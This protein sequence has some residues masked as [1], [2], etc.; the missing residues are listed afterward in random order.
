M[1]STTLHGVCYYIYWGIDKEYRCAWNPI[2]T[3]I[4]LGCL[5]S[6]QNAMCRQ[7]EGSMAPVLRRL[8]RPHLPC[9]PKQKNVACPSKCRLHTVCQPDQLIC[10]V[11][12]AIAKHQCLTEHVPLVQM[13]AVPA[14]R[15]DSLHVSTGIAELNAS[16]HHC[17]RLFWSKVLPERLVDGD[18]CD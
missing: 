2:I 5:E 1:W 18:S 4:H 12:E 8:L 10:C 11:S 9:C 13:P 14:C 7:H 15:Q 3:C 17:S 6:L 16:Q